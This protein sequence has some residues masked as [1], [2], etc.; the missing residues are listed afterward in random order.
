Y[1][2]AITPACT[3]T[4]TNQTPFE[5]L[6]AA[7]PDAAIYDFVLTSGN[8]DALNAATCDAVQRNTTN[9]V[10]GTEILVNGQFP[11]PIV[12]VKKNQLLVVR[13]ENRMEMATIAVHWHGIVQEGTPYSDGTSMVSQ[14]P[15]RPGGGEFIYVMRA[16]HAGTFIYH[17]H[18]R[19]SPVNL[20]GMLIVEDEQPGFFPNWP[21][22]IAHETPMLLGDAW[23]KP[24]NELLTGLKAETLT[25]IG[26]PQ[27]LLMNERSRFP[28][29]GSKV[30]GGCSHP[31]VQV[32]KE[33]ATLVR[34]ANAGTLGFLSVAVEGHKFIVLR[35]DMAYVQPFETKTLD[36]NSGQRYDVLIVRDYNSGSSRV[37]QDERDAF[38]IHTK[39]I[40]RAN[41]TETWSV[42]SYD[43]AQPSLAFADP[44]SNSSDVVAGPVELYG[45]VEYQLQP[46]ELSSAPIPPADLEHLIDFGQ[47]RARRTAGPTQWTFNGKVG[48]VPMDYPLMWYADEMSQQLQQGATQAQVMEW[49][50]KNIPEETQRPAVFHQ[51]QVVQFVVQNS[52]ATNGV[53]EQHPLHLH[54]AEFAI[55]ASGK[56]AYEP[57]S[58]PLDFIP[59]PPTTMHRDT[60]TVYASNHTYLEPKGVPGEK[61]GWVAVRAV[62]TTPGA[63]IFH[64]HIAAHMV[65]GMALFYVVLPA[66]GMSMP[67]PVL[68]PATMFHKAV[69]LLTTL[70]ACALAASPPS[71]YGPSTNALDRLR[72]QFPDA[73]V[74][75]FVL[76]SGNGDALNA[77]TCDAVHRNTTNA[78]DGTEIL[79]NGQFP[80]PAVRVKKNQLLVVRVENQ[81]KEST[82]TVHWH[83]IVQEGT[84]YSDGTSMV[85]QCPI[86]PGGGEFIY[87]MRAT[88]AGTFIYHGH[89]RLSPVN[90]FG[91]LIVE[92]E[93]P[94]FFPNWPSQI[95][96]ETQMLLGDAWAKPSNEQL[97]G[98][99]AETL[100][101]I[102]NP[103]VLLIN[104]RTRFPSVGDNVPSGCSHPVIEVS[105]RAPTLVRVANAGTLGFMAVSVEAH[106]FIVLRADLAYV[107]PYETKSLEVNSGQ[108][109]DVLIVPETPGPIERDGFWIHTKMVYRSSNTTT[110]SVLS[111][112]N[113]QPAL[114]FT[115][116]PAK[117]TDVVPT[118]PEYY[119]G[120]EFQLQPFAAA[121][122]EAPKADLEYVIEFSQARAHNTSGA[123]QWKLNGMAGGT[124]L[125][126]PLLW[127]TNE[128]A[129]QLHEGV[130]QTQVRDWLH[131]KI[132][133]VSQRP[134]VFQQ[135]QVVQFVMQNTVAGN[136]VCEQHPLHL[137]FADFAVVASGKGAYQAGSVP[138]DFVPPPTT[139]LHR[140]TM[141]VF[142]SDHTAM[143]IA[144]D[145]KNA[146]TPGDKCGWV[147]VRAV[148]TTPGASILHCHIAA[149][150]VMGMALFYVVLPVP[151]AVMPAPVPIPGFPEMATNLAISCPA[152]L[153]DVH[154]GID[155]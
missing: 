86:R 76:T 96:Y 143:D 106:K 107:Q 56:G 41:G 80:G 85:S 102:G 23:S 126:Y 7:Y 150:M 25:W 116:P 144:N 6:R 149:H 48:G 16:T 18:I 32:S 148:M 59:S 34:V 133:D 63:S 141:T 58:V 88:H 29:V 69:A 65:M 21:A 145:S 84:P 2:L 98:L 125:D 89:I 55:V 118:P 147:A 129:K 121:Q 132:P 101:W 130:P 119:G 3:I 115:D 100:A 45:G 112:D 138:L 47:G 8:G 135:N 81:M 57:G 134:A 12:R 9:A 120:M 146:G 82:I 37:A 42:L 49:L 139:T 13:V 24:S 131:A 137:H 36:V 17:G 87:V 28:L 108:R 26:N 72:V 27:V 90:L 94:G 73:A 142:G 19:L 117:S 74:Y 123:T 22:P 40:S 61:C 136:G 15:I 103:Q 153:H 38:W 51:N 113:N 114:A 70:A 111:Y 110:W 60:I 93:Q 11:A 128:M 50:R 127:Y 31:V 122:H 83:G 67:E 79:V 99:K 104:G 52:V 10:D 97:T 66:P 62:M 1:T 91:M 124:P 109:Y 154:D 46:Y 75:N 44:P 5:R 78:V 43:N 140:D 33:G 14:C 4:P 53:C 30:P 64:C 35:A 39:M 77:A 95:P 71:P 54:F 92:D 20:F 155:A 105:K 152:Y 151:G 68:I